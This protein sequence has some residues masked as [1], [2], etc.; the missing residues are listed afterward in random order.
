MK[1]M[2]EWT[3]NNLSC[4]KVLK[5]QFKTININKNKNKFYNNNNNINRF[6]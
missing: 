2:S 6:N 1:I 4:N 5:K 3:I